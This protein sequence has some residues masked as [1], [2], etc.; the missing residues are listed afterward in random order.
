MLDQDDTLHDNNVIAADVIAADVIVAEIEADETSS[1]DAVF[2]LF[3]LL[4][5][6]VSYMM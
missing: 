5:S 1:V 2:L 4:S 6:C 3:S